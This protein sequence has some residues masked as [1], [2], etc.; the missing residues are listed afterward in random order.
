MSSEQNHF[1][2]ISPD[3]NLLVALQD[4]PKDTRIESN[5][6]SFTLPNLVPAKHKFTETSLSSGSKLKLYGVLVGETTQEIE[7]GE[8]ITTQNAVHRSESYRMNEG[9]FSWKIPQAESWKNKTF[10]GY[11]RSDGSVGTANF[12]LVVPMVFCE[13]GN[14]ETLKSSMLRALG[15][16]KRNQY[17]IFSQ[18]LADAYSR[19]HNPDAVSL[20]E[21]TNHEPSP[22]FPNIDG[23]KF[24][25]H[26]LG[27]GET[28]GISEELCAL[29]AGY[30]CN[31]NV[32]GITVLSLGCQHAQV[33]I[34]EEEIAKRCPV[35][36]KPLLIFEQQ[37]YPSE[38]EMMEQAIRQT[39]AGLARINQFKRS[40]APLSRLCL[41][42]ECG[43]SDGFSGISANPAMGHAADL[44]TALGGRVILSE[45]PEL[46]GVEQNIVNRCATPEIG[47]RFIEIMKNYELRVR[48][49]GSG[50]HMNPSPGNVKDGLTTDAIKSAGA[51]RK[52]GTSTVV[53]VLDFP[54]WVTKDGLS[55]LCTAGND[56]ESTTALA[57]AGANLILFSTGLGTPTGNPIAPVIKI[58]SNS[59]TAESF[60]EYID[61]DAGAVISGEETVESIGDKLL[62]DVIKYASGTRKTKATLQGRDDFLP[63]KRGMSL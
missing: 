45:F 42:M 30:A 53:D 52:G 32:S 12:W 20:P 58:S 51:A 1:L 5:G 49:A 6:R 29:L 41:G 39:Y 44:L 3:D 33:S 34:M 37:K 63:W 55:L 59:K 36:D 46:C 27:C 8:R 57:G 40:P 22:I 26:G 4:L 9:N 18:S 61:F 13:N 62:S 10:E 19:G 11:H 14:V 43:A 21:G 47:T 16:S 17:E 15:L 31:P 23:I 50:F 24:L 60:K 56:V 54:G 7:Q 48:E 28:R 35:F 38:R 25:T 2:R